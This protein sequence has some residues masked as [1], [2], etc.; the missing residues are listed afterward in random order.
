M[1]MSDPDALSDA[2]S[3]LRRVV[4]TVE[5]VRLRVPGLASEMAWSSR[6][7]TPFTEALGAWAADLD[8]LCD[9][10]ARWEQQL[11]RA[12]LLRES[13]AQTGFRPFGGSA[14]AEGAER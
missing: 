8:R 11:E 1:S 7:A 6:S 5:G 9:Q 2:R 12:E 3:V 10:L 13:G 14:E 4:S